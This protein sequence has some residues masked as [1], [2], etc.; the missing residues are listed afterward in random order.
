MEITEE[1]FVALEHKL[2]LTYKAAEKTRKYILA[3][4][5]ISVAVV[6]IPLI[7]LVFAAPFALKSLTAS[8]D[9]SGLQ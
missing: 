6:V 4:L 5:I 8:Y 7:G 9:T 2:E 1:R 3:T